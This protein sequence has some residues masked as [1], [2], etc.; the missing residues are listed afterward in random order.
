MY[1]FTMHIRGTLY[2]LLTR[3]IQCT[4]EVVKNALN[5]CLIP[6]LPRPY[7]LTRL[8]PSPP[9]LS[10]LTRAAQVSCCRCPTLPPSVPSSLTNLSPPY[11]SLFL[12]ALSSLW[13][14]P[15]TSRGNCRFPSSPPPSPA[16]FS[17][18][19]PCRIPLWASPLSSVL[20]DTPSSPLPLSPSL[21]LPLLPCRS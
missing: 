10:L 2:A 21:T 18:T 13:A 7:P 9:P 5:S 19:P 3:Y 14:V 12:T 1:I 20:T 17:P 4:L 11:L 16:I 8:V 6:H 15:L